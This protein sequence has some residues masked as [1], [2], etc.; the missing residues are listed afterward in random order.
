MSTAAAAKRK[1]DDKHAESPN[2][3]HKEEPG[4]VEFLLDR[5]PEVA[6]KNPKGNH[7]EVIAAEWDKL[8]AEKKKEW[9]EKAALADAAEAELEG[10][11]EDDEE[12]EEEEEEYDEEEEDEEDD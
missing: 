6:K 7:E 11:E 3:K 10:D 4:F 5:I 12:E 1:P 2:K 8:S 9:A